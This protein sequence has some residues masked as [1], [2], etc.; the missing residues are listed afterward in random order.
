MNRLLLTT[1]LIGS[2]IAGAAEVSAFGAGDINSKNPY[3]LTS[4][5]KNILKNKNTLGNIDSKVKD[6]KVTLETI[7]E[8]IDGLESI[9][10]GD[11]QKLNSSALKLNELVKK[12]EENSTLTEKHSADIEQILLMQEEIAKNIA[13]LKKAVSKLSKTVNSINRNYNSYQN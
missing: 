3:G 12:V 5:E 10:E 6:V 8:R 4:T 9:Y 11:S 2:T 7:N 1:L 13:N